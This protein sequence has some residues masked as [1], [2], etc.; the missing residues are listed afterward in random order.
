[1]R[2]DGLDA[3]SDLSEG[4]FQG[5][6]FELPNKYAFKAM[7]RFFIGGF[8]VGDILDSELGKPTDA[9]CGNPLHYQFGDVGSGAGGLQNEAGFRASLTTNTSALPAIIGLPTRLT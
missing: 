5:S 1:M 6:N 9:E 4:N 8:S 7:I 3:K 2:D